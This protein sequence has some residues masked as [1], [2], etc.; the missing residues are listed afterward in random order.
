MLNESQVQFNKYLIRCYRE[1]SV[2]AWVPATAFERFMNDNVAQL[3]GFAKPYVGSLTA[4]SVEP[5][6]G[7][8]LRIAEERFKPKLMR[9][10]SMLTWW[11]ECLREVAMSRTSWKVRTFD[12][13]KWVSG[14]ELGREAS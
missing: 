6:L 10:G 1:T 13:W 5:F 11:D 9:N 12:G 4:T 14:W 7:R 8:A 2:P 3:M